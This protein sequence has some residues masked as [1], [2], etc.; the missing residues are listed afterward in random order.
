MY[1]QQALVDDE[2]LTTDTGNGR[3]IARAFMGH[4]NVIWEG[5]TSEGKEGCVLQLYSNP[6]LEVRHCI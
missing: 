6:R 3:C 2:H 4:S 5:K 1:D